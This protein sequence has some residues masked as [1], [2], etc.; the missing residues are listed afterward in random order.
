MEIMIE[1]LR[2]TDAEPKKFAEKTRN[3]A[4]KTSGKSMIFMIFIS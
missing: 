2:R 1:S 4:E 3:F